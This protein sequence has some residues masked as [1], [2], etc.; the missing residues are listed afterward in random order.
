MKI[1]FR[2][3]PHTPKE[4]HSDCNSVRIEGTFCKIS[5]SLVKI[6][7]TLKGKTTVQ[8][9]RCGEDSTITLDEKVDFLIS[10]GIFKSNSDNDELVIEIDDSLIDFD[11][12]VDGEISSIYSDYHICPNCVDNEFIEQEY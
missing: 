11:E 12:I 6:D 4:F 7:A 2:K 3:V 8:C 5:P 9:I 1:E 10:D